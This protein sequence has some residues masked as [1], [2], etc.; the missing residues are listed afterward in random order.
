MKSNYVETVQ[1]HG[2]G[3]Y[4]AEL[5][6]PAIRKDDVVVVGGVIFHFHEYTNRV[7]VVPVCGITSEPMT[8]SAE[9]LHNVKCVHK[10]L[11]SLTNHG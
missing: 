7:K 5:M 6:R 1:T 10:A 2:V 9:D 8:V 11:K 4:T 3:F